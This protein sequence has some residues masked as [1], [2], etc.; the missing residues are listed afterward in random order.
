MGSTP[1]VAQ[2]VTEIPS[3]KDIMKLI[4][5][6]SSKQ[7]RNSTL[8]FSLLAFR[9]GSHNREEWNWIAIEE[10]R[11][12]KPLVLLNAVSNDDCLVCL[13]STPTESSCKVHY[14]N[15]WISFSVNIGDTKRSDWPHIQI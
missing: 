11:R 8:S 4:V 12:Q 13:R 14:F 3:A 15:P 7:G 5:G 2:K 10:V 6:E 9:T 1:E